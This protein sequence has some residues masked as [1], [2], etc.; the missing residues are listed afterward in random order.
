VARGADQLVVPAPSDRERDHVQAGIAGLPLSRRKL[1]RVVDEDGDVLARVREYVTPIRRQASKWPETAFVQF[2]ES[3]LYHIAL[4]S[5]YGAG[6]ADDSVEV[7][8]S[9]VPIIDP[10]VFS[11]E[12]RFRVAELVALI[13]C[14]EPVAPDHLAWTAEV[15]RPERAADIWRIFDSTEYAS[16][17]STSGR[18]GLARHPRVVMRQVR[19]TLVELLRHPAAQGL[20]RLGRTTADVAGAPGKAT[21]LIGNIV[22]SAMDIRPSHASHMPPFMPLGPAQLGIYVAALRAANPNASPPPGAIYM[23]R[24][25]RRGGSGHSWLSEG[26]EDKLE[27]EAEAGIEPRLKQLREAREAQAR[28]LPR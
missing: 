27:R 2:A 11:G 7:V 14:Y 23:V 28:F 1:V 25:T 10:G 22:E 13:C 5:K 26:E 15:S 8:R 12:A 24:S 6:I 3:F 21:E 18:L 4:G 17:A 19:R 16:V 9:F 20:L